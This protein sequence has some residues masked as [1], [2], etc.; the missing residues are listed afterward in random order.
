MFLV[1]AEL[2]VTTYDTLIY[3]TALSNS[4]P[5]FNFDLKIP[6]EGSQ[7]KLFAVTLRD[8]H[9]TVSYF[10]TTYSYSTSLRQNNTI[11]LYNMETTKNSNPI[12]F[13]AM[14]ICLAVLGVVFGIVY[15]FISY[16]IISV[17]RFNLLTNECQ[18]SSA[19]RHTLVALYCVF[20]MIYSVVF[21]LT[22]LV[23]LLQV[24][25]RQDLEHINEMPAYHIEIK[26]M[27]QRN[28]QAVTDFKQQELK[29]QHEMRVER[30]SAC[31]DS[32]LN[33]VNSMRS[34]VLHYSEVLQKIKEDIET[35]KFDRLMTEIQ[36]YLKAT[37]TQIDKV[38]LTSDLYMCLL[39]RL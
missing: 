2:T 26:Q 20:K 14:L 23:L 39:L 24:V 3:C 19:K 11:D 9:T 30:L 32:S 10:V 15:F 4:L 7:D 31:G 12:T 25:C 27:V 28:I 17:P 21:S 1:L 5:T 33:T 18:Y 6:E 29:R 37:K 36:E 34:S 8:S 38:T 35:R 16:K 13:F 22:V